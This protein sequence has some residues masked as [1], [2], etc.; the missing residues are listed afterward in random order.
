MPP[1]ENPKGTEPRDRHH[2]PAGR[3]VA[4]QPIPDSP[5]YSMKDLIEA[6]ELS[7][8]TIRYYITQKLLTPA[9]GKGPAASYTKDHLLRLKMIEE[10]KT[11]KNLS[12]EKIR[13]QLDLMTTS[14]LEAHFAIST[15]AIEG[16]WRRVV[17][18]PDLELNIREQDAPNLRF[19]S[20]VDE[21]IKYA[22]L[23]MGQLEVN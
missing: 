3:P 6:T 21:I 20:A 16:R 5:R 23:I 15:R 11:T 8:R 7:D 19:E 1:P 22:R 9:Q 4:L 12:I 2:L 10:L 17:F 14:D 18:H 13:V